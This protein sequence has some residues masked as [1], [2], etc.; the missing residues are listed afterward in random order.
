MK[1]GIILVF[2]FFAIFSSRF[3]VYSFRNEY[4]GD[5]IHEPFGTITF[6]CYD[7]VRPSFKVEEQLK[8]SNSVTSLIYVRRVN[9][10]NCQL[11]R[12][13]Y[14]IWG[15]N[16]GENSYLLT[17]NISAIELQFLPKDFFIGAKRL[18]TLI[19][20]NNRLLDIPPSQFTYCPK[21]SE[22]DYS[23]NKISHIDKD[24][25]DGDSVIK[26]FNLSHNHINTLPPNVFG[27][28]SE[29]E[30]LDLSFNIIENVQSNSFVN[31]SKLITLDLSFSTI[32]NL[33]SN[34]FVNLYELKTLDLSF[35]RI[36]GLFSNTFTNLSNLDT[37]DLS[38]NRITNLQNSSVTELSNLQFLLLSHNN[39]TNIEMGTFSENKKLSF[40]DLSHNFIT[41]MD[42]RTSRL[43]HL[44]TLHINENQ[45]RELNGF[46][47]LLLPSLNSFAISGNK[48]NCS[49]LQKFLDLF[50]YH[51]SLSA[52]HSTGTLADHEENVHGVNCFVPQ[53][54]VQYISTTP[55][56]PAI[57]TTVQDTS[58]TPITPTI[59]YV[60]AL[61]DSPTMQDTANIQNSY[62]RGNESTQKSPP[63]QNMP[64]LQSTPAP[65]NTSTLQNTATI[66]NKL[67]TGE[68]VK[69]LLI[70]LCVLAVINVIAMFIKITWKTNHREASAMNYDYADRP[71]ISQRHTNVAE[72]E[73]ETVSDVKKKCCTVG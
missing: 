15:K 64:T 42:F 41:N 28:L 51:S 25:F 12:I 13:K 5:C 1:I 68:T 22:V 56:T 52:L 40:L 38:F 72:N 70:V 14:N 37:L 32:G 65:Q 24:A 57:Q 71:G 30:I 67:M 4:I 19:A 2:V 33:Q 20:T 27:D 55:A 45:L 9:L 11:S 47:N 69:N 31:L 62:I 6:F 48:F 50:E 29:M 26:K 59:Q 16:H 18:T 8:C 39:L 66:Q 34:S 36:V 43:E 46:K 54:M 21:L 73:Y 49:Y 61:E 44:E 58:T 23:F 17:L 10:E 63:L 60:P 35:N 7:H 3:S 53:I